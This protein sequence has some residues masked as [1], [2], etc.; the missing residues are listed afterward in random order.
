MDPMTL[1]LPAGLLQG[2]ILTVAAC[3]AGR[4]GTPNNLLG[5]RLWSTT[6]S[7]AAWQAGHR[8]AIT[9]SWGLLLLSVTSLGL[10]VWFVQTPL[11]SN[12]AL[13]T[14]YTLGSFISFLGVT[15]WM[16][17]R[18]H[19]AAKAV[20]IDHVLQED[21]EIIDALV[22]QRLANQETQ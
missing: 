7:Q 2:A 10:G 14:T 19:R 3:Y 15:L 21:A 20:A 22:E 18:A 13:V 9:Y 1:L 4:R 5:I 17:Y 16:I 6:F 8:A 11:G 12:S